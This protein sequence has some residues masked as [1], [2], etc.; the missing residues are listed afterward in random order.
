MRHTINSLN[1]KHALAASLKS[2][3]KKTGPEAKITVN[4]IVRDCNVNRNTFYYHFSDIHG[5][6]LWILGEDLAQIRQLDCFDGKL[7]REFTMDY[8]YREHVFLNYA[9]TQVGFDAFRNVY[10]QE[11][12]IIIREYISALEQKNGWQ[13]DATYC[14]FVADFLAESVGM[15]FV[16]YFRRPNK[17]PRGA[18][19]KA[20]EII[21][22]YV[23][24]DMLAHETTV[25]MSE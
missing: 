23:I 18:A 22:S 6:I 16:R 21:F 8:L 25:S 7:I 3:T 20:L 11:L 1:T 17:Y 12:Q 19:M 15:L 24:P 9:F 14:D 5:L 2:L 13:L 4:D 10:A